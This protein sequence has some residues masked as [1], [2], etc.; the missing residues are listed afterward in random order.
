MSDSSSILQ[1]P[2]YCQILHQ[3]FGQL[4]C[5]LL[6]IPKLACNKPVLLPLIPDCYDAYNKLIHVI[7]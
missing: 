6:T 1:V 3:V 7:Q 4:L 5:C 2:H